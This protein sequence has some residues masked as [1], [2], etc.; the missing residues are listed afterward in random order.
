M[1]DEPEPPAYARDGQGD[2]SSG[3]VLRYFRRIDNKLDRVAADVRELKIRMT[4]VE[5]NIASLNRGFD[6]LEARRP[7]RTPARV[8]RNGVVTSM[9][10]RLRD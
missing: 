3:V 7:R 8:D 5:E 9:R 2:H 6:R 1:A 4:A 10:L